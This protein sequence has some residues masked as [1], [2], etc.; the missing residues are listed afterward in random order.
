LPAP[1]Q[2]N[3]PEELFRS[4][5][6]KILSAKSL[7]IV[8]TCELAA[9]DL[10]AT[11][12]GKILL[13]QGNVFRMELNGEQD[14]KRQ[15]AL[16]VCDGKTVYNKDAGRVKTHPARADDTLKLQAYVSRVG[17]SLAGLL[18]AETIPIEPPKNERPFDLD[19]ATTIKE[20]KAGAKERVGQ[21]QA[22]AVE[23]ILRAGR[24][25]DNV[26]MVV[27]IDIQTQLPLKRTVEMKMVGKD[28]R[29]V[30]TYTTFALGKKVDAKVFS[31]PK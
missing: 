18:L 26:R 16:M 14:G 7:E 3:D 29:W 23:F 20:F 2:E 9:E 4:M 10:K 21:K 12:V 27:W 13:A 15:E 1:A 24:H 22:Q 6:R 11:F 28:M 31:P 8:C 25:L 19:K 5:E 30:E 17:V